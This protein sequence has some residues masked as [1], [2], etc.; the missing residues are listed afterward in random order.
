MNGILIILLTIFFVHS[1][2]FFYLYWKEKKARE[3][4]QKYLLQ[5]FS[6]FN[7]YFKGFYSL[8]TSTGPDS[9]KPLKQAL[10]NLPPE[11]PGIA[12]PDAWQD[13]VHLVINNKDLARE[14]L[15]N[16]DKFATR[17]LQDKVPWP[18]NF[19]FLNRLDGDF[20]HPSREFLR[21]RLSNEG[22]KQYYEKIREISKVEAGKFFE[23][24][25]K[26]S[27]GE[28]L[29]FMID[30]MVCSIFQAIFFGQYSQSMRVHSG[31][32]PLTDALLYCSNSAL[33]ENGMF[34]KLNMAMQGWTASLGFSPGIS[35][36]SSLYRNCKDLIENL[37][38]E[39]N[40]NFPDDCLFD[41]FFAKFQE[42]GQD[43]DP[44]SN[45]FTAFLMDIV[46]LG[47]SKTSSLLSNLL[48]VLS[49]EPSIQAAIREEVLSLGVLP[50]LI[51]LEQLKQLKFLNDFI[52]SAFSN[53]S[54]VQ[55]TWQRL[56]FRQ[57]KIGNYCF[58]PGDRITIPLFHFSSL[59]QSEPIEESSERPKKERDQ[60][61][62]S[63]FTN[64]QNSIKTA[65]ISSYSLGRRSCTSSELGETIV[66]LSILNLI[67]WA[68]IYPASS[69]QLKKKAQPPTFKSLPSFNIDKLRFSVIPLF[70]SNDN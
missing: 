53:Y 21:E 37:Y 11:H 45:D 66:K 33:G 24:Y 68:N 22:F 43:Y 17:A 59:H 5:G 39:K 63:P 30:H 69:I 19:G 49:T 67:F 6:L 2:F 60:I 31:R 41:Q 52:Q 13:C 28:D 70:T 10:K 1:A 44:D 54:P 56:V 23:G 18:T 38:Q 50:Q 16:E 46:V 40:G 47:V 36:A 9:M 64:Q 20:E 12:C 27:H 3:K 15:L 58:F 65:P 51:S 8:I 48:F 14:I 26:L 34:S 7:A 25:S 55:C 29:K 35:Q 32:M 4:T 61:E 42:E 57:Y 62:S